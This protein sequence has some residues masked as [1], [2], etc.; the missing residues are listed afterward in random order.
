MVSKA[1]QIY[2]SLI[3]DYPDALQSISQLSRNISGKKDFVLSDE[4]AFNFDLIKNVCERLPDQKEKSPDALFYFDDILYFIEF[5]EGSIKKED[6]RLKIHEAITTLF[7]YSLAK[8]ITTKNEFIDIKIKYAV[9]MRNKNCNPDQTFLNTL[10][11]TAEHFNLK[12]MEGL[13]IEETRIAFLPKTIF[14][15]LNKISHG[16]ITEIQIMNQQQNAAEKIS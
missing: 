1:K 11:H 9:V 8:N 12:N 13:L 16:R 5:K 3:L 7:Q 15:L 6:I 10:E 2:D 14:K 4:L